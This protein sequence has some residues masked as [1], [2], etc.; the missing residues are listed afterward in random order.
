MSTLANHPAARLSAGLSSWIRDGRGS[1]SI[2]FVFGAILIVTTAVGGMDLHRMVDA[3]SVALR[4][5][6]TMAGYLSLETA[7]SAAFLDDWPGSPYARGERCVEALGG[8]AVSVRRDPGGT[9]AAGACSGPDVRRPRGPDSPPEELASLR[10]AL[11]RLGGADGARIGRDR[12]SSSRSASSC[13]GAG[14]AGGCAADNVFP[15]LFYQHRVLPVH[16]GRMPEEP[17]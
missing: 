16:G 2:E 10:P 6:T 1:V 12:W 9:R 3:R 11:R 4:A 7:P 13:R 8:S 5:A 14:F 15:T 17:S